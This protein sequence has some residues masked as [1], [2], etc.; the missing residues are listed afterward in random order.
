MNVRSKERQ[1]LLYIVLTLI[2]AFGLWY[3][4]FVLTW[5]NFW[6]KISISAATLAV[7]SLII[8]RG[9][10]APFKL[11]GKAILIG[12]FSAVALY[13]IFFLGKVIS[14]WLFSF[15]DH[16]VGGIYGLGEG[17]NIWLI[18]I[19]L[20]CVTGPSEEL[21]WRGFIQRNFALRLGNLQGFLLATFFYTAVHAC[22]LNF[23][24]IGASA[25]AGIFWGI[26]YWKVNNLAPVILSHSLWSAVIFSVAPI[27]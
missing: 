8:Q 12:L 26:L 16:Q 9:L 13:F 24:L 11:D 15:A 27:T 7:S 20:L 19:L 1:P 21:F 2:L 6:I 23:M 22:T 14:S 17:S 18:S 3:F 25:V 4:A 10:K 5:G